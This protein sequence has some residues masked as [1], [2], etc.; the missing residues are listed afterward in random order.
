M[1]DQGKTKI[2]SIPLQNFAEEEIGNLLNDTFLLGTY[3]C[4]TLT[5]LVHTQTKGNVFHIIEFLRW[6]E[7]NEI[8]TKASHGWDLD[9]D[10]ASLVV[11]S[12][13]RE[14]LLDN[15]RTLPKTSQDILKVAACLGS[16]INQQLIQYVVGFEPSDTLS[17][18]QRQGL[19]TRDPAN[20]YGFEHDSIQN[21]AYQLIPENELEQFHVKLGRRIWRNLSKEELDI[22]IFSVVSQLKLGRRL[23]QDDR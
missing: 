9:S 12:A 18:L 14:F 4:E 16:V 6:L 11:E 13:P 15:L 21:A 2:T 20:L 8:L 1:E 23:I 22:H 5:K 17:D 10:E 7:E 19:L 3:Q